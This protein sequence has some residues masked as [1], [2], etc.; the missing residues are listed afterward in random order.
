MTIMSAWQTL[1]EKSKAKQSTFFELLGLVVLAG[2]I[3]CGLALFTYDPTDSTQIAP[4]GETYRN[5]GGPVGAWLANFLLST[6]GIVSLL[7]ALLLFFCGA[8]MALGFIRW[9]KSKR[10]VGLAVI[11]VV[12]A[13]L[14]HIE[15]P[16][17]GTTHLPHGSGGV[18]GTF[19]GNTLLKSI[20]YGG[21]VIGLSFAGIASLVMSGN[22]TVSNTAKF[23]EYLLF[24]LRRLAGHAMGND[25]KRRIASLTSETT[26]HANGE[27]GKRTAQWMTA[28]QGDENEIDMPLDLTSAVP[29]NGKPDLQMFQTSKVNSSKKTDFSALVQQL[30][31]H[32]HE[33]KI[34]G[35]ITNTTEGPVVT[36][37]EYEPGAGTKAARI[38]SI[39]NDIARMLRAQSV[40]VIPALPGRNTVGI[41]IPSEQRS[42][43][44]FGDVVKSAR[45][46]TDELTLPVALGVDTFGNP[47]IEDLVQM[48]HLLV[49]GTTGSGKSVFIHNLIAGLV[50]KKSAREMRFVFIDPKMVEL[51][52]YKNL[53]HLAC[54]VISE[55]KTQAKAVLNRLVAEMEHRY[56]M[57]LA[58]EARNIQEFNETIRTRR[59][60]QFVDFDGK[61]QALPYVVLLIDEF[62]DLILMLGR[63]A[64]E[65]IT[66]LAQKA[67]AAGIHLIIATQRPSVN[68]VTGLI[69]AN[70]P[71]RIAFRVQSGVDSRTILDQVGAETLLGKGDML[72]QSTGRIQR[73][74]AALLEDSEV[75]KLVKAC[76]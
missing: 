10:F 30:E 29:K 64:E 70:F 47:V 59:R 9:P 42:I 32:L 45:F 66:R 74:H 17:P 5:M 27:N 7:I 61:W 60:S 33:F 75:R 56:E 3:F 52:A 37:V 68:V 20:G 65:L 2:G 16:T 62:A 46:R 44:R 72:Y 41:E 18:I 12:V 57:M 39:A 63:P 8:L 28:D 4:G 14:L 53:P 76:A 31:G 13:G 48:P 25:S 55:V 11:L 35:K 43:I 69:K 67:R 54:P 24:L 23:V 58:L 26:A 71:T 38:V 40:R 1:I 34:E 49:A 21:A 51:A 73:L 19:L 6:L 36:T 50:C 22:L 15:H